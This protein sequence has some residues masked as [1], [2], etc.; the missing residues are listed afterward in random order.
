MLDVWPPVL[1]NN[2]ILFLATVHGPLLRQLQE[3]MRF[4]P[5][6][7]LLWHT[8]LSSTRETPSTLLCLM[9]PVGPSRLTTCS[10]KP[11]GT[12]PSAPPPPTAPG[13]AR[14]PSLL[15]FA[16]SQTKY[17]PVSDMRLWTNEYVFSFFL[18]VLLQGWG[19]LPSKRDTGRRPGQLVCCFCGYQ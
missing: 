11:A 3:L 18:N 19:V 2:C 13:T 1:E 5:S 9:I 10:E 17:L 8:S 15:V 12:T 7:P 6:K 14:P 16:P 4:G